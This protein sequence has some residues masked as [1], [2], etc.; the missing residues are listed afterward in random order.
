MT[1]RRP[2]TNDLPPR[3]APQNR[4]EAKSKLRRGG[5][6]CP[7]CLAAL[8]RIAGKGRL[9]RKCASCGAQPQ[10]ARRCSR[11]HQEA[12]WETNAKAACQ[13]CGQHGSKL[14]VLVGALED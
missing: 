14:G 2:E 12:I 3:H 8:P 7:V 10:A 5:Q 13:A 1:K 4:D 11:C 6:H 9:A